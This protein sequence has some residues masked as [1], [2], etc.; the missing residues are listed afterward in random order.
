MREDD[1]PL[2]VYDLGRGWPPS[3]ALEEGRMA[4]HRLSRRDGDRGA[5]CLRQLLFLL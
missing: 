2:L 3:A 1:H 4:P 5:A